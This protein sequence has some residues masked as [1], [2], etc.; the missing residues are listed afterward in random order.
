[1][2]SRGLD[3]HFC[4]KIICDRCRPTMFAYYAQV[5]HIQKNFNGIRMK[6][7]NEAKIYKET[8]FLCG[9]E[10]HLLLTSPGCFLT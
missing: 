8:N 5:I 2:V 4:Q 9:T 7:T 10:R 6:Q 1:M 3:K